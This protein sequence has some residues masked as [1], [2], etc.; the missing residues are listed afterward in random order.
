M[1]VYMRPSKT[2]FIVETNIAWALPYWQER[3]LINRALHW[4]FA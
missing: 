2:P 4:R 3:K 1:Y